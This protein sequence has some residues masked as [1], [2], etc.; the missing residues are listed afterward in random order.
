M[1]T[2]NII[3]IVVHD[4][5]LMKSYDGNLTNFNSFE[6]A[7]KCVIDWVKC[8]YDAMVYICDGDPKKIKEC[9][10][11]DNLPLSWER[12]QQKTIKDLENH[13]YTQGVCTSPYEIHTERLESVECYSV[14]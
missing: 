6:D 9:L 12:I 1:A 14:Y 8:E 13:W 10:Y 5:Y 4:G 11:D 2:A 7:M 3:Y